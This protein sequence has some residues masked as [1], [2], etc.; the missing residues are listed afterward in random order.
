MEAVRHNGNLPQVSSTMTTSTRLWLRRSSRQPFG[1]TGGRSSSSSVAGCAR[2][3]ARGSS[4]L[5]RCCGLP[6]SKFGVPAPPPPP[7]D[8]LTP[9]RLPGLGESFETYN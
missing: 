5:P 3:R 9:P 7:P 8:S 2:S 1:S 6:L 4:W